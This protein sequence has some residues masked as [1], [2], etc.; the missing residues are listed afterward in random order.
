[1]VFPELVTNLSNR[2]AVRELAGSLLGLIFDGGGF[3]E[4][5][6]NSGLGLMASVAKPIV[7]R[8]AIESVQA[9]GDD[10]AAF[11]IDQ[12]HRLSF[13]FENKTGQFS[14]YHYEKE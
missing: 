10:Q 5:I 11:I 1:M 7:R 14:P 6:S 12:V 2:D 4:M 8:K 9:I 3:E 13:E